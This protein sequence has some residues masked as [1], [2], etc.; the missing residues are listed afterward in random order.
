MVEVLRSVVE[1]G[2]V[3]GLFA[4]WRAY[5]LLALKPA[6]QIL[7]FEQ[8]GCTHPRFLQARLFFLGEAGGDEHREGRVFPEG[9]QR[10]MSLE[11]A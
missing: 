5:I 11:G 6:I 3:A 2:G 7:I 4:G 8:V 10:G 9:A 1:E